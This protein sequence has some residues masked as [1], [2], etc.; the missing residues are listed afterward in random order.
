[1]NFKLQ[2][3]HYTTRTYIQYAKIQNHIVHTARIIIPCRFPVNFVLIGNYETGATIDNLPR[4]S[5]GVTIDL[6]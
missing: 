4:L 3:K 6:K 1:M 5:I 2:S